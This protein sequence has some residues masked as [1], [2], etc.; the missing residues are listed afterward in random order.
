M[1][2]LAVLKDHPDAQRIRVIAAA[3]LAR[4]EKWGTVDLNNP[5]Q[6]RK[7]L[8]QLSLYPAGRTLDPK[9][10]DY[11]VDNR[12]QFGLDMGAN[13]LTADNTAG[14]FIDLDG[15]GVEEFVLLHVYNGYIVELRDGH[16]LRGGTLSGSG[17]S[18]TWQQIRELLAKG[19][20]SA[21]TP[22][23][24]SFVVGGRVFWV[25]GAN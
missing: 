13:P 25:Q 9:L 19:E 16:W 21:E 11:V 3:E 18:Q 24:K 2:Q 22:R 15:D 1:K 6:L 8:A 14:V 7:A 23:W 4:K 5:D 17:S 12:S 20:F 10:V